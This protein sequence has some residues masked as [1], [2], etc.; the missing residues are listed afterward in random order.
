MVRIWREASDL[1]GAS[2]SPL[3]KDLDTQ[4]NSHREPALEAGWGQ[5]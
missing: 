5:S 4:I 3:I 2:C 1:P